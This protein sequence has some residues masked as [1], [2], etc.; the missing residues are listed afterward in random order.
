MNLCTLRVVVTTQSLVK[1]QFM[2]QLQKLCG[3]KANL[4]VAFLM[5]ADEVEG[6]LGGRVS[7]TRIEAWADSLVIPHYELE[8]EKLF[9]WEETRIAIYNNL[10]VRREA[11]PVRVLAVKHC[12]P[13]EQAPPPDVLSRFS[14][15]LVRLHLSSLCEAKWPGIYFL[16]L[17]GK[18]VYVGQTA[19]MIATRVPQ[20]CSSKLFDSAFCVRLDP[21]DLNYVESELINELKPLYNTHGRDAS[22]YAPKNNILITENGQKLLGAVDND[23][24][25]DDLTAEAA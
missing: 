1:G 13:G 16:C 9:D 24:C 14:Q 12:L 23:H 20:H 10:L 19:K 2:D 6:R 17:D 5:T 22:L 7:A 11:N 4:N 3:A 15:H 21:L 8:G 25:G 18:V